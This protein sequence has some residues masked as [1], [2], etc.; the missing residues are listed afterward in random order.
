MNI[1]IK[2]AKADDGK[3]AAQGRHESRRG[4]NEPD[5]RTPDARPEAAGQL[6]LA[7]QGRRLRADLRRDP[8]RRLTSCSGRARTRHIEKGRQRGGQA[9]GDVP[10]EEEARGEPRGLQAAARGD[11]A[12][13]R[14]AAQAAAQQERDGR[15]ADRH[16]PG[17]PRPRPRLRALQAERRR[18]TSP[19]STRSCRSTSR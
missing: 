19:S 17:R 1:S 8:G 4:P 3:A 5:R 7:D 14:R 9:E 13:V 18:R 2:R 6:A 11:R 15:A 16:Q 12:V 10:R